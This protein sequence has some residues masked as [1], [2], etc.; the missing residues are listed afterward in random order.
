MYLRSCPNWYG[1]RLTKF[2]KDLYLPVKNTSVLTLP[3]SS[4]FDTL[5]HSLLHRPLLSSVYSFTLCKFFWASL[6]VQMVQNL[7]A[8]QEAQPPSLGWE[9]PLEKGMAIHY[10]ILTWRIP[11][12]EEPGGLQS[13]GS[14]RVVYLSIPCSSSSLLI[15]ILLPVPQILILLKTFFLSPSCSCVY[16]LR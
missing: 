7:S 14:H 12:T 11:W 9:D 16:F 5:Y 4:P 2:T 15:L 13:M 3:D 1:T 10:S 8:M 6:V